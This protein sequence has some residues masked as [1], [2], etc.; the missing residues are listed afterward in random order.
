MFSYSNKNPKL[1][2]KWQKYQSENDNKIG[3]LYILGLLLN[4]NILGRGND[5]IVNRNSNPLRNPI[6]TRSQ[7]SLRNSILS[8]YPK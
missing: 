5:P 4:L 7:N 8:R 6:V 3:N 2:K 1:T